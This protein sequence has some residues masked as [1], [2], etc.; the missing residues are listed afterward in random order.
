VDHEVARRL[1]WFGDSLFA[2]G[3]LT[4]ADLLERVPGLSTLRTGWVA[5]PSVAAYLGDI[6]RVRVFY[7]GFE[8]LALDPRSRGVLDL[9]KINLW[10]A[11]EVWIEQSP[12]EVRVYLRSW[13]V[14]HTIPETRADINTGDQQTNLYRGFFGRRFHNGGIQFGAQQYGTT[15]PSVFGTSNDQLGLIGRGGGRRTS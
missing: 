2:T 11:E 4:V 5:A 8:M 14:Y 7:D 12:E 1:H 6:Q 13:R 9:S 10:S 3:A 15:P